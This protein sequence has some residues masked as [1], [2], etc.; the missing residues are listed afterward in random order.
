MNKIALG[1]TL[2]FFGISFATT[3]LEDKDKVELLTYDYEYDLDIDF[4]YYESKGAKVTFEDDFKSNRRYL[5]HGYG[6]YSFS[7]SI[8]GGYSYSDYYHYLAYSA[9]YSEYDYSSYDYSLG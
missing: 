9:Y 8:Y 5:E 2:S 1:W 7:D 6:D 4:D 3:D